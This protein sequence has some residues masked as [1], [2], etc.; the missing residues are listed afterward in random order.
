MITRS[1]KQTARQEVPVPDTDPRQEVPD[2]VAIPDAPQEVPDPDPPQEVPVPEVEPNT[3]APLSCMYCTGKHTATYCKKKYHLAKKVHYQCLAHWKEIERA[4]TPSLQRDLMDANTQWL[5][6]ERRIALIQYYIHSVCTKSLIRPHK[7][8]EPAFELD[9]THEEENIYRIQELYQYFV[10]KIGPHDIDF[11]DEWNFG[12]LHEVL[13]IPLNLL[14]RTEEDFFCCYID[15][16]RGVPDEP[17]ECPI[18]MENVPT[19]LKTNC[20]HSFCGSCISKSIHILRKKCRTDLLN[21]YSMIDYY[22]AILC[23][24][25]RGQIKE[26]ET[27]DKKI[28]NMVETELKPM[29]VY[30]APNYSVYNITQ[31]KHPS[32]RHTNYRNVISVDM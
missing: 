3:I 26:M 16:V 15:H 22:E 30:Y 19:S 25:C 14:I 7:K 5:K 11:K 28:Y 21:D 2:P 20:G 6:E 24:L 31:Y 10:V 1:K 23:P 4:T 13:G 12:M 17:I 27:T 9:A 32:R 29:L 18:C 8:R